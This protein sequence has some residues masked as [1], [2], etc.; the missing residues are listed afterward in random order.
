MRTI[1]IGLVA[2]VGIGLAA[3]QATAAPLGFTH[4]ETPADHVVQVQ[5]T[6]YCLRLR[7]RCERKEERGESG[8]GNCRRY[9]E[10]CSR[11]CA[12]LRRACEYRDERGERGEGNCQR[13]RTVCG[14]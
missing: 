7:Y 9:R 11:L 6:D 3:L 13:Y 2:A 1:L 4:P 14:R 8:E 5:D 12:R 10:E